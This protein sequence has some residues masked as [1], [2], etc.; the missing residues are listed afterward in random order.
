MNYWLIALRS[1]SIYLTLTIFHT[2]IL[3]TRSRLIS[4][5]IASSKQVR[6]LVKVEVSSSFRMMI[7][8]WLKR[9]KVRKDKQCWT[10]LMILLNTLKVPT[11]SLTL[12]GSTECSQSRQK[13]L[14]L[15]ISLSCKTHRNFFTKI[16]KTC[17]LIWKE[18]WFP[19]KSILT[20]TTKG[21]WRTKCYWMWTT[22][23]FN[24][25]YSRISLI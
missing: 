6:V 1:L 3:C 22:L 10:L 18:T 4:T 21:R 2:K 20:L 8:S 9:W 13:S 25:T 16:I 5:E 7:D 14:N 24:R 11:T 17:N 12:L 19:E 15:L 23:R